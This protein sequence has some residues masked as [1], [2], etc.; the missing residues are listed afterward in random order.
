MELDA[1][2]V[3]SREILHL[4]VELIDLVSDI[5]VVDFLFCKALI[6]FLIVSLDERGHVLDVRTALVELV[7]LH[8]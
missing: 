4:L 3:V 6:E 5:E 1:I 7:D 2:F 8:A